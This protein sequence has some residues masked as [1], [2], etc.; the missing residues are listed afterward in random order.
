MVSELKGVGRD[1]SLRMDQLINKWEVGQVVVSCGP[2]AG[3]R[4]TGRR[5]TMGKK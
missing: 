3:D 2:T 1:E 4:G 5:V